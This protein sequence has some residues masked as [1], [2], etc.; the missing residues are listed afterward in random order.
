VVIKWLPRF[1]TS[2]I[3][4][5]DHAPLSDNKKG[6]TPHVRYRESE[7]LVLRAALGGSTYSVFNDSPASAQPAEEPRSGGTMIGITVEEGLQ[8]STTYC[9]VSSRSYKYLRASLAKET[10]AVPV[11]YYRVHLV[12]GWAYP[13]VGSYR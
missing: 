11:G 9:R 6:Y 8:L 1:V 12:T 2:I 7:P 3:D 5:V 13:T 10:R 4:L